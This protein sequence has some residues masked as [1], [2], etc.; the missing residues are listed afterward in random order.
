MYAIA[1]AVK[2][3]PVVHTTFLLAKLSIQDKLPASQER[4]LRGIGIQE[5]C[6]INLCVTNINILDFKNNTFGVNIK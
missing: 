3:L 5:I 6:Y 2:L 4:T 1:F